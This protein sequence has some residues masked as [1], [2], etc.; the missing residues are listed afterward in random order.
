MRKD[1]WIEI[2]MK[3]RTWIVMLG[4]SLATSLGTLLE[5]SNAKLNASLEDR[6]LY[7]SNC[8]NMTVQKL[9]S[10]RSDQAI[11]LSFNFLELGWDLIETVMEFQ[12]QKLEIVK[13]SKV[14]RMDCRLSALCLETFDLKA[15]LKSKARKNVGF[16]ID[17]LWINENELMY[18]RNGV[19]KFIGQQNFKHFT[20]S[21]IQIELLNKTSHL[22]FVQTDLERRLTNIFNGTCYCKLC[23]NLENLHLRQMGLKKTLKNVVFMFL[24]LGMGLKMAFPKDLQECL[25][26]FLEDKSCLMKETRRPNRSIFGSSDHDD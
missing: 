13:Q 10:D 12:E 21:N 11:E 5:T 8:S 3:T 16:I 1:T 20:A 22:I 23:K 14:V 15:L 2:T 26:T 4:Y 17:F 25:Q 18:I 9:K 24:E 19:A 6:L 7:P